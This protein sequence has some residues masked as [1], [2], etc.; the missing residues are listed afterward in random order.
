[1]SKEIYIEGIGNIKITK[2]KG[3]RRMSMSVRPFR[4]VNVTIPYS[5]S[6]RVAESFVK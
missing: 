4:Y 3:V 5:V 6:Y 1:M 2:K